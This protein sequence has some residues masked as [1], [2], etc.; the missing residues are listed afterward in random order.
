[1]VH[2]LNKGKA[3][4]RELAKELTRLFGSECRRGQQ[5]SGIEG[6]DVVGLDGVHVECKRVEKLNLKDAVNQSIRDAG[7]KSIPVV[8]HRTNRQPWLITLRLEDLPALALLLSQSGFPN[9]YDE[10][11]ITP[12]YQPQ[13]GDTQA[14]VTA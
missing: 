8:C 1:V 3:G 7:R 11:N 4:E 9:P 13:A 12:D 2:S 10:R 14:E 6:E 5:F